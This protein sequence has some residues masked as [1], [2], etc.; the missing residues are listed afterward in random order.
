MEAAMAIPFWLKQSCSRLSILQYLPAARR[1]SQV[2]PS[3]V[4]YFSD[5]ILAAPLDDFLDP[6][7]FPE[8]EAS[9]VIHLNL[10]APRYDAAYERGSTSHSPMELNARGSCELR[11]VI[12]ENERLR[13]QRHLNPDDQVL[14]TH[15]AMGACANA[16]DAFVNPGD[17]VVLFDPCSPMFRIGAKSRRAKLRWVPTWNEDGR[18]RFLLE[19][20][21]KAMRGAMMLVLSNPSNPTGGVL[22]V[23]EWDQI[24][25]LAK[26]QDVLIFV[27]DS[28]GRYQYGEP[29]RLPGNAEFQKRLLTAGSVS[30]T[31]GMRAT[32]IGWLTGPKPLVDACRL[33]SVLS[34][35][36]VPSACQASALR[37]LQTPEEMFQPTLNQFRKRRQ[38]AFDRLKAMDLKPDWPNGGYTLWVNVNRLGID[39]R[40]F[41]ER[42]LREERVLVGSGDHYGPSGSGHIRISYAAEDGRLREGLTRIGAFVDRLSGKVNEPAEMLAL[43]GPRVGV[44]ELA[45]AFSRG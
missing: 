20:L 8:A 13:H 38:Y 19:G 22:G 45:P 21:A 15:G 9:D 25:W 35:P 44:T 31:Y 33:T 4:R 32:R 28:F 14:I 6:L 24:A 12:A 7:A 10:A 1:Y 26:R 30:Q 42:L 40:A 43:E 3:F 17:P 11:K 5:R 37:A 41:A 27:D 18:C 29:V 36:F 23:E 39:G 34:A 2:D 16:I